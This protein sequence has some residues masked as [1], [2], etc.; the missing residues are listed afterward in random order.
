LA[1]KQDQFQAGFKDAI[2]KCHLTT[3]QNLWTTREKLK[4]FF[5][6]KKKKK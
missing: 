1:G 3:A 5:K 4:F 2:E 6:F